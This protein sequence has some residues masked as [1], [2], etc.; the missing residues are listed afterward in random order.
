MRPRYTPGHSSEG[1]WRWALAVILV[2]AGLVTV[3]ALADDGAAACVE[4]PRPAADL[5]VF[6]AQRQMFGFHDEELVLCSPGHEQPTHLAAR[7]FVPDEC[8]PAGECAGVLVSHGFAF[9]KE[10]TAPDMQ[11]LANRGFYVLSY[12][13]RGHGASGGQASLMGREEIADQVAVLE[14]FHEYVQPTKVGAY[15]ISQGG[16]HALMAAIFN[17][18]R[19]RAAAFDSELPC[20]DGGRLV[21][22]IVPFQSPTGFEDDGTC[23]YFTHQAAVQ[24]RLHPGIAGSSATCSLREVGV[25]A[26]GDLPQVD[27]DLI[28]YVSRANRIDVPVYLATSF[29]DRLVPPQDSTRMYEALR[30]RDVDT[31]LMV[32]HDG[33]GAIGANFA[34]LDDAFAWLQWQ[35]QG[36]DPSGAWPRDARV[37]F[38]QEWA[39]NALGLADDWPYWTDQG[40]WYLGIG[41][42]LTDTPG[43][44]EYEVLYSAPTVANPPEAPFS[45]ELPTVERS[46]RVD[47]VTLTYLTEPVG[48]TLEI[49]GLPALEAWISSSN[50][51]GEGHGQLHV[52]LAE[53]T[54]DGQVTQFARNR[55]GVWGLGTEPQLVRLDLT[56]AAWRID[57]SNRLMVKIAPADSADVQP[58]ISTDELRIHTGGTYA[59][60]LVTGLADPSRLIAPG[61]TGPTFPQEA[62]AAIC[63]GLNL[64]CP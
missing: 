45:G 13:V 52:S 29:F 62:P 47:G 32:T 49:A 19:A 58:S 57:P 10:L 2:V 6:E 28:D 53:V 3:P 56:V 50:A 14:W 51:A 60:R 35:L 21:D 39:G 11:N 24:S 5:P 8:A 41:G 4:T 37:A 38:A 40:S 43:D 54:P 15:G 44:D 23:M 16:A 17:C 34:A 55:I 64:P 20:D 33:H 30:G 22:A 25:D 42:A 48:N 18:G 7:L 61:P 27:V 1:V 63:A 26:S 36:S 12:D 46:E 31:R 9:N 59:S